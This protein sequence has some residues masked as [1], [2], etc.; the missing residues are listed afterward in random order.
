MTGTLSNIEGPDE[1]QHDAAF[2][3]DLHSLLRLKY[4]DT[5]YILI[6]LNS[7]CDPLKYTISFPILRGDYIGLYLEVIS[8]HFRVF[9]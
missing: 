1:M 9:S 2:H 7:T 6:K 5:E 8:M 3:Q 4:L